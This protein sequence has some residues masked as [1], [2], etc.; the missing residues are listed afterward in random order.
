MRVLVTGATGAVG[1]RVV[2]RLLARNDSVVALSRNAGK[3]RALL[4]SVEVLEADPAVEGAWQDR[5]GDVDGVVN[6][7]GEKVLQRWSE[8]ARRRIRESRVRTTEN[9]ARAIARAGKKAVLVSASAEAYYARKG[10]EILDEEAPR[11]EGFLAEVCQA[12]EAACAPAREAGARV[13][14]ARIGIVMDPEEGALAQMLPPFKMFVGGRAG[15]GKQWWS[16]VHRDDMARLLLFALDEP[17]MSGAFNAVAPEPV[18]AG[19]FAK[20]LGKVLGRPAWAPIPAF[21][22][23]LRFGGAAEIILDGVRLKPRRLLEAGFQFEHPS[24][25]GALRSLV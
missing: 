17:K 8:D 1:R 12:W 16:W 3:A 20:I 13:A 11:G 19:E 25:E 7:A 4:G 10:D 24:L 21:A 6:L 15:S 23:K 22:L 14:N 5:L 18:T 9:V 2:A